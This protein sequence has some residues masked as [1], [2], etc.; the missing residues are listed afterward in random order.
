MT[1]T[2]V[3]YPNF[4]AHWY[5]VHCVSTSCGDLQAKTTHLGWCVVTPGDYTW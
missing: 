3:T 1:N 5:L 4:T 2:E